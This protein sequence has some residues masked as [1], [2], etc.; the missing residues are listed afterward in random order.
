MSDKVDAIREWLRLVKLKTLELHQLEAA[1]AR[2]TALHVTQSD[3]NAVAAMG[4]DLVAA[5]LRLNYF[6]WP[7]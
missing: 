1:E 7:Q 6:G 4:D 2:M 3:I 5:R